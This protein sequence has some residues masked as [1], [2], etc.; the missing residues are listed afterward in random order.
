LES[1]GPA[2]VRDADLV[3]FMVD[4]SAPFL[5]K[6]WSCMPLWWCGADRVLNKIDLAAEARL[7]P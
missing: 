2:E 6:I 3:L 4:A 7:T 1:S 5:L